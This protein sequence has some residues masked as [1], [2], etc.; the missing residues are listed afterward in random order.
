MVERYRRI[1]RHR[2]YSHVLTE[3]L[4]QNKTRPILVDIGASGDPPELWEP[5]ASES[6]YVGLDPD[7]REMH[8]TKENF[9]KTVIVERALAEKKEDEDVLFYLTKSPFCSSTLPPLTDELERYGFHD[10]FT[11][12]GKTVAPAISFTDL[13]GNPDIPRIDWL[14][15]DTQ[16][17]DLRLYKSIPSKAR[18]ELLVVDVEPGLMKAYEGEDFFSDVDAFMRGEGFWLSDLSVR[19][20][21]R[22]SRQSLERFCKKESKTDCLEKI[23]ISPGW[24][25][26]RYLRGLEW[27]R[28]QGTPIDRYI[29]LWVFAMLEKQY[30][31]CLDISYTIQDAFPE[32]SWGQRIFE[33]TNRFINGDKKSANEYNPL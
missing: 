11:V 6:I 8:D 3:V 30:G 33:T 7:P 16:G 21:Q 32:T 9:F 24:V 23:R 22:I 12:V 4:R 1:K 29:L 20:T 28:S 19:G 26:A 14:K 17:C 25:G 5:I 13:L 18:S 2:Q 27:L 15:L 10:L 31:Y